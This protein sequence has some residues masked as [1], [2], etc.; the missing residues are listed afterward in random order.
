MLCTFGHFKSS[1]TTACKAIST[2]LQ[3]NGA[4]G[5][6][7]TRPALR[8]GSGESTQVGTLQ[9]ADRNDTAS[10]HRGE[11]AAPS[12]GHDEK[13]EYNTADIAPLNTETEDCQD[14]K[15]NL[16]VHCDGDDGDMEV[17]VLQAIV[18]EQRMM[19]SPEFLSQI[20]MADMNRKY[21]TSSFPS[22][23]FELSPQHENIENN[24]QNGVRIV[25]NVSTDKSAQSV[26]TATILLE[27]REA[28]D[29]SLMSKAVEVV[30]FDVW[31]RQERF[32]TAGVC[33]ALVEVYTLL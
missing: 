2:M 33:E 15:K 29:Q 23:N 16:D 28:S 3:D 8:D 22:S 4:S 32:R 25:S 26:G 19:L 1:T 6:V 9:S 27:H 5:V 21:S 13:Y 20:E 18:E 30:Q 31:S 17:G 7:S 11:A 14:I 12:K 10:V 24:F